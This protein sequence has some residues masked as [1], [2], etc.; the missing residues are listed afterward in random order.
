MSTDR[1]LSPGVVAHSNSLAWTRTEY[2]RFGPL[3]SSRRLC[4]CTQS[5]HVMGLLSA[6]IAL[7]ANRSSDVISDVRFRM[8][9]RFQAV[10]RSRYF[11]SATL[12]SLLGCFCGA[13]RCCGIPT[14]DPLCVFHSV[15]FAFQICSIL[16]PCAFLVGTV[17]CC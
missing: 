8:R 3:V 4:L 12:V 10:I 13:W 15:S 14:S 9:A 5:L 2:A 17:M 6:F 7:S 11:G 1:G 16:T